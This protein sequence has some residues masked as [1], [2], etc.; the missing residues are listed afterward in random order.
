MSREA[1]RHL[2]R[3]AYRHLSREAYRHLSRGVLPAKRE[4]THFARNQ[5]PSKLKLYQAAL[6][7]Y[8]GALSRFID[9]SQD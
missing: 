1:Y 4:K 2:S 6:K 3:E 8:V 9:M 5:I 7:T